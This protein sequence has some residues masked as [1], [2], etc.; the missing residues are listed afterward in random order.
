MMRSDKLVVFLQ[1][2]QGIILAAVIGALLGL[3]GMIVET[4][5]L[6]QELREEIT[7]LKLQDIGEV[8]LGEDRSTKGTTSNPTTPGEHGGR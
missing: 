1:A 6:V 8:I 2:L 4:R 5:T 3:G 7:Q